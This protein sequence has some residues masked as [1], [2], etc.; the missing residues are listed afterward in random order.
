[1]NYAFKDAALRELALTHRSLGNENGDRRSNERLEFL[2]D[3]VIELIV[4]EALYTHYPELA[5]GELSRLRAAIVNEGALAVKA[6]RLQLG[7]ELRLSQGEILTGGRDKDSLLAD[8]YEALIGAIYLDG[9]FAAAEP[10]VREEF[11]ADVAAVKTHAKDAKTELQEWAQ[12]QLR[13]LPRYVVASESGPQHAREF[14]C[15]VMVG[16][17]VAGHGSGKSKKLAEQQAAQNAL[18]TLLGENI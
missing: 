16:E 2:G 11:A 5:E 4:S 14:R 13:V 17:R 18:A 1:M 10:V 7:A 15:E 3:A 9:G 6:R 12:K 8:V